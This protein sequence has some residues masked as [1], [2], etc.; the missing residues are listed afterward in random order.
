[1]FKA[2]IQVKQNDKVKIEYNF[3]DLTKEK[4]YMTAINFFHGYID[5]IGD[6][7]K[8]S[9]IAPSVMT[10][11]GF[12]AWTKDQSFTVRLLN[13]AGDIIAKVDDII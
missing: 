8:I 3:S 11:D 12:Q 2:K 10:L 9:L 5:A 1:M 4:L 13:E 7:T 6:F